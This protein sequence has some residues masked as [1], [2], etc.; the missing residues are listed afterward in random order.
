MKFNGIEEEC[1]HPECKQNLKCLSATCLPA[2]N[3]K[4]YYGQTT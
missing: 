4:K 3:W 2:E 1:K